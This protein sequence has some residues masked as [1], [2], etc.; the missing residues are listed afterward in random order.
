MFVSMVVFLVGQGVW[1]VV[2]MAQLVDEKVSLAEELG[3][4]PEYVEAIHREEI[5]RQVMVGLEGVFFLL[6]FFVGAWLIYRSLVKTKELKFHQQNFLMAVTHEL[7]TPLASINVYLDTLKS[8]KIPSERKLEIIPRIK[9]DVQ[10][11][12][13]LVE[14]VLEAG[15]FERSGYKLDRQ[16]LDFSKVV[17]ES[18]DRLARLP[19]DKSMVINRQLQEK[20]FV[21]GDQSALS[22]AIDAV[23]ENCIT[24]ND[25]PTI[26]IDV[27]LSEH[28]NVVNLEIHDN[29]VGLEK[30][31]L[32]KIFDRFYRVGDGLTRRSGG[33]GLGLYLCREIIVAHGGEARAESEGLEKGTWFTITLERDKDRE[34]YSVG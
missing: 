17:A 16:R 25:K 28:G 3:A 20:L 18:L 31:D 2:F 7:K 27:S 14:N 8:E 13:K 26:E 22:R 1:W 12:E 4:S 34:K 15:R 33:T 9:E 11:L 32:R 29:G 10:R 19:M 6:L 30:K 24:Y 21:S 23:L 5:S